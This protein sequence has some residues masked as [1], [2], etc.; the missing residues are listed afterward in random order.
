L[1]ASMPVKNSVVTDRYVL[2][3]AQVLNPAVSVLLF[4]TLTNIAVHSCV[5]SF[6]LELNRSNSKSI[7]RAQSKNALRVELEKHSTL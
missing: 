5:E 1:V 7:I 3:D 6:Y 4:I 2:I